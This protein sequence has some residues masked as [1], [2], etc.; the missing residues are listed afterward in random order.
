[1]CSL[2]SLHTSNF[3]RRAAF[4]LQGTQGHQSATLC[5]CAR[6]TDTRHTTQ[7]P[8]GA[9]YSACSVSARGPACSGVAFL[10]S[11]YKQK[12]CRGNTAPVNSQKPECF[13]GRPLRG[14]HRPV[15]GPAGVWAQGWDPCPPGAL[16]YSCPGQGWEGLGPTGP[17]RPGAISLDFVPSS[18][19]GAARGGHVGPHKPRGASASS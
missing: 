1:M 15:Q 13:L 9:R 14:R 5:I 18:N 8:T 6:G 19:A 2:S 7:A 17:D 10:R 11:S 16:L 12:P 3:R 4:D